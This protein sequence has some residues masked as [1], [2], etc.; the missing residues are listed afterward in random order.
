VLVDAAELDQLDRFERLD[1]VARAQVVG[2]AGVDD[3][4]PATAEALDLP[5]L[6]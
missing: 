5:Q 1:E 4:V 2:V 3:L 6:A